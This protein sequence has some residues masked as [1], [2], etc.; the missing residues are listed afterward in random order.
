M[1]ASFFHF[2][3]DRFTLLYIIQCVNFVIEILYMVQIYELRLYWIFHLKNWLRYIEETELWIISG[4][5]PKARGL[6]CQRTQVIWL[7]WMWQWML[8]K[9]MS[10]HCLSFVRRCLTNV[11]SN[12]YVVHNSSSSNRLQLTVVIW[13][14]FVLD[15]I[16]SIVWEKVKPN[17]Y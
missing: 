2:I 8:T 4:I 7:L 6:P 9:K 1:G 10:Y 17:F 16:S 11:C 3:N 13:N 14:W 15:E 12:V 5:I